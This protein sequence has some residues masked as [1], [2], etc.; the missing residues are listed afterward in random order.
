MGKAHDFMIHNR[1]V[2]IRYK[3]LRAY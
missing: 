1:I 2:S 3:T